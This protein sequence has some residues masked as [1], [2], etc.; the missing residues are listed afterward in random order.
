MIELTDIKP[1]TDFLRNSKAHVAGLKETGKPELLTVNGEAAIVVQDAKA[2][3]ELMSLAAQ[4]RDDARLA[5]ALKAFRKGESGM[6][7]DEAFTNLRARFEK[8]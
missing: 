2:Y 6:A 8:S 7:A 4:A 1:L 5:D 3:Q